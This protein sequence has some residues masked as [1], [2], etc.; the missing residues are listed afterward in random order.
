MTFLMWGISESFDFVVGSHPNHS[1]LIQ[2]ENT[3]MIGY[4]RY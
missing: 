4:S 2:G 3:V 1:L